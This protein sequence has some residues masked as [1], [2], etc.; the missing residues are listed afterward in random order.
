MIPKDLHDSVDASE[1]DA[2]AGGDPVEEKL[3]VEENSPGMQ[4]ISRKSLSA[5][6]TFIS[7]G[8]KAGTRI[9]F[10]ILSCTPWSAR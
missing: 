4:T 10:T 1:R 3:P 6:S 2:S 9:P 8:S 5:G 7:P